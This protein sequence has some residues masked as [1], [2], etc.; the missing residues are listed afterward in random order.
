MKK[1]LEY[2]VLPAEMTDFER[3]YLARINR[4]ALVFFAM[5]LPVFVVI[6]W[7]NDTRPVV[8]A[9]LS[10]A[11]LVGPAIAYRTV[12]NPRT[13]SVVHGVTAMFMGGLLVHFGQGPVQIE[14]HFYF[15]SLVAMCAVFGNPLV[16]VGAAVT[17]ALHHLIVW[18][19]LPKSV[20]NYDASW[21]VVSV[22]A[23][24]VVLESV[25]ACFISRSFFDNVIGLE[26][27]VQVRTAALDAKN[28]DMRLLLDNVEQG[29]LTI[30]RG[31]RLAQE[32]SAVFDEWFDAPPAG[33]TWFDYLA[34]LSPEFAQHSRIAWDEVVGGIMPIELTLEQMPHRL[35]LEGPRHFRV[36]YRPIG[37]REP[38]DQYLVLVTD[39]TA[40]V[41]REHVEQ[42]AREAI[43]VFQHVLVDRAG[44]DAFFEEGANVIDILVRRRSSDLGVVKRAIHTLKGNAMLQGLASIATLCHELED[45]IEQE[46]A[47]PPASAYGELND[48][49]S[50][51]AGDMAKLTG[52]RAKVI[53]IDDHQYAALE[54][55]A[56]SGEPAQAMLRRV[57]SLKLES[58]GKR[59]RS[60]GDQGEA[61]RRAPREA[62]R[63]GGG[64]RP[65]RAARC[66]ALG[67]V[68]DELRPCG[69]KRGRPRARAGR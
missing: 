10:A 41:A 6:A 2:L 57:R 1:I 66:A 33:A 26:K 23:G 44:F 55:A 48:R 18:A 27:I 40:D 28:R 51:L 42:E 64:R 43:A 3:R 7:L 25:A 17:V 5:H 63:R 60:F 46:N 22:H 31:G 14:M 61:H 50:R 20:F 53:E 13:V 62:R 21:W 68:L 65:W 36:D 29:F 4:I 59:L 35:T 8:A 30:D 11:V 49:W 47:A 19:V 54:A 12:R 24:F 52:D 16:I 32:R 38:H 69:S 15:F 56:R 39:I 37:A 34:T 9:G 45:Y 58:A 67:V